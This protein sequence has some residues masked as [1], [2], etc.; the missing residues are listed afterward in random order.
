MDAD[1]FGKTL[2][3]LRTICN[4]EGNT[5][6][7]LFEKL[8]R[9]FLK[10]DNLYADRFVEVYAWKD[11]PGRNGRGDFGVDLVGVEQDGQLCAIQCKFFDKTTLTKRSID[12]FLEAGS[13]SEFDSM[14]L[15]YVGGGYGK[16]VQDA[17]EGHGCKVLNFESLSESNVEWPDLAAGLTDIKPRKARPLWDHQKEA[18]SNV[19]SKLENNN[20]GQ[21]IMACGTGKTLTSLRLAEK[22]VGEGGLVLYAVPSI[23]LMRQV[24]R[25]WAGDRTLQHGYVGV[26]SDNTVSRGQTDIP[27]IEMEIGVSTDEDRIASVMRRDSSKMTV[28][29]TTYQS[30]E[31]IEK[32]QKLSG[33]PFDLVLCDE[34]H[35]TTGVEKG[36][37]FTIIHDDEKIQA[38]KRIYMTATPKIYKRAVKTKAANED[39]VLYSMDDDSVESR[40]VFGPVMFRLSFSDAIDAKLLTDYDVLTLGVSEEYGGKILQK[41]VETTGDDGDIN[42]TDAARMAGLYRV[43]E[44]PDPDNDVLPLQT[45]IAYTNRI[46]DSKRF[47]NSFKNLMMEPAGSVEFACDAEHVDS[48]QNSTARDKAMQWLRDSDQDSNECRVV[49]NAKCLSEGVDVPA[50]SAITFLN[51]KS[52]EID[53]IQAIGRV[54]RK[55]KGKERGY[56]II[57]LGIPPDTEPEKILNNEK[58]FGVVWNVLRALRS[59]DSRLDVEVNTADLKKQLPKRIKFIGIDREGK[60]VDNEE[61]GKSF[62]LGEL[63]VPADALYSRIVE[64]VGDRQYLARWANDVAAVV[65]RIQERIG[66]VV[67][68]GPARDKFGAYMVGLRDIIHDT[69]SESEGIGMLAQHMVT[70]RIFGAMFGTDNFAQSN[71][72]SAALDA[73]LNELRAHGLDTELRDL[74]KFYNSIELRVAGLDS[75][76]AR[77]RVISELYGT[78][79]KKAFSKMADR[80]GIVYTPTE[81]VDF[82]L[83]SVDHVLR[84]NFGR[85]LTDEGVNVIDP[86]TGAGTFIARMMSKDLDL[87]RDEDIERKYEYEIFAN[88]I[89]LLA[90]YIAA[91][92][93]ESMY[94]QRTGS[95]KQFEGL[96][97]TDTFSPGNLDEHTGDVMAGPKKR[98]RRQREAKITCIVGN[99]P[100]SAGQKS[101]NED[102][103]NVK[104]PAIEGRVKDTYIRMAPKGN[105][106]SLYN[107]YIK[108]LR[109]ASDRIGESGV[110]GFITPSAYITGIAEAGIRACLYEEFTDVYCLDLLGQRGMKN[111]GNSIFGN[112]GNEG[113]ITVGVA[114][115]I[116]VKN[117]R[118]SG[119][120]IHYS[121]LPTNDFYCE[122]KRARVKQLGLVANIT[123]WQPI[124]PNRYHDWLDQRGEADESWQKYLPIGSKDAKRGKTNKVMFST[125]SR[126]LATARDGWVYNTSRTKLT[127]N[128]KRHI[129]YCNTQDID[130]FTIDPK[131]AKYNT[132]LAIEL[133]KL[134]KQNTV[135]T[136]NESHI[137]TALFRPFLKQNL[138]FDPTFIAAKYKIPKFFP[139]GDVKNPTIMVPNKTKGEFSTIV[140]DRTPDL[141]NVVNGQAFPLKAKIQNHENVRRVGRLQTPDSRLQ[142]PDSRLQTPDSRLQTQ[143]ICQ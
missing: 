115:T 38:R 98:I 25:N 2:Q 9:S 36:S 35:R 48:T 43:L 89:V 17:L 84:E 46:S 62:S 113:G 74:E 139:H 70:R 49:S 117:P 138:Y 91:V 125:Y 142:T 68:D 50:L 24:I 95:F 7:S 32:A 22:T 6:G 124:T 132:E 96:S 97:F 58:S 15:V 27:I 23:S 137:R 136:L 126:G 13:R 12:S 133:K 16:N 72:V 76:D 106:V 37:A 88:E 94:G 18:M 119:C 112:S 107:S 92:N 52:S 128:M 59:H 75:H 129:D 47:A 86:F 44:R 30:M 8:V 104:Y 54:M 64:E 56:V 134:H 4:D 123:D 28:I 21:L 11:Y 101:A 131:Q 51:P 140:M 26:C 80:L 85:G 135:P 39:V 122:E 31:V 73:V 41:I 10:T 5:K 141:Q 114:I 108:A 71:P 33:E 77:Q 79:F 29:F 66:V 78:F 42:L 87:I 99:P 82:I 81:V 111:N 60:R 110:I 83:R 34:A 20:R 45:A 1:S 61:G 100:Y 67:A 105:Q 102:N 120:T 118:K 19:I 3:H 93:C 121:K 109:Q 63:D 65:S 57:P 127:E 116:L 130:N 90:Y 143:R 40:S 103:K 69:I 55:H 53:I 14:M